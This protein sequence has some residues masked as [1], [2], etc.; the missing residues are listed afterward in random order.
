[1]MNMINAQI[2]WD[3]TTYRAKMCFAAFENAA[4]YSSSSSGAVQPKR[5]MKQMADIRAKVSSFDMLQQQ[6]TLQN[7][8][9]EEKRVPLLHWNA[10][11]ILIP[12]IEAHLESAGSYTSK[13]T[14]DR[15]ENQEHNRSVTLNVLHCKC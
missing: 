7:S 5:G 15:R 6:K 10:D 11:L 12:R 1:M 2:V 14:K 13:Q 4:V 3:L 8:P 9:R